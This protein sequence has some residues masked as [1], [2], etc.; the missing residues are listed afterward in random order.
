V[1]VTTILENSLMSESMLSPAVLASIG[2]LDLIARTVAE[3]FLLGLHKSPLR[4]LSQEFAE[5]RQY[6]P[7]DEVRHV[8][9]RLYARTDRLYVKKFEEETNAPVRILIDA[10]K[11]LTFAGG[12]ISK[13]DYARY[14][15]AAVS[16]I[17]IRQNDRVGFS[18]FDDKICDRIPTR[19]SQRHLQAILAALERLQC[20]GRTSIGPVL[21]S[22]AAQWKRRGIVVLISDLYDLPDEVV[23]AAARVRRVGQNLIVLHLV[24][25]AEKHLTPS[26]TYQFLDLE[27]GERLIADTDRIRVAYSKRLAERCS[28]YRR[29]FSRSGVEYVEMD[30]SEPLDKAL[31]FFLRA[32]STRGLH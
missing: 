24:D 2:R 17:A 11:S 32:R 26:G 14:L 22:E 8:D 6:L 27:T 31:A 16:Y 1:A 18:W 4:G 9:W 3:G 7:G 5:H 29:E 21:L 15:A 23:A 20:G 30:T 12:G 25:A 28:F 19:G 10:S 13:L